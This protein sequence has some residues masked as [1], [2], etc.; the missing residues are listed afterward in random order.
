ME[1]LCSVE[2]KSIGSFKKVGSTITVPGQWTQ[3]SADLPEGARY[4]A[5]RCT[6]KDQ[7]I[8]FVD[9]IK[10]RKA[11]TGLKLLGYNVYRDGMRLN[12]S[13]ITAT[14]YTDNR[15]V[16]TDVTYS[17]KAVYNTGESRA[18]NAVWDYASGIDGVGVGNAVKHV[19]IYDIS[20]RQIPLGS[21]LKT[22]VYIVWENGKAHKICIK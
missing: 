22:G 16:D 11:G 4:F 8:L 3:Y 21:S 1:V 20:G 14:K 10:Y 5:L 7:Y 18:A 6:S 19:R 17:V 15:S 12:A 13:P 2:G 9:D